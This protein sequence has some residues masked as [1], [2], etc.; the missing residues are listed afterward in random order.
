[1][2]M[3]AN[4]KVLEERGGTAE[5]TIETTTRKGCKWNSLIEFSSKNDF[6]QRRTEKLSESA[7]VKLIKIFFFLTTPTKT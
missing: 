1:M 6:L 4:A 3:M 5:R 7:P 2:W